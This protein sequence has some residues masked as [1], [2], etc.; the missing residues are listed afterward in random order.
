MTRSLQTLAVQRRVLADAAAFSLLDCSKGPLPGSGPAG[1]S[2]RQSHRP[3]GCRVCTSCGAL[4][5]PP[6][7]VEQLLVHRA[8]KRRNMFPQLS[9]KALCKWKEP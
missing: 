9:K 3:Q 8:P 4:Q 1:S 6:L 2:G 7:R 5:G